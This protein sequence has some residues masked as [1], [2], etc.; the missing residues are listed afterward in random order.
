MV[1]ETHIQNRT[2]FM[3]AV[4]LLFISFIVSAPAVAQM[5]LPDLLTQHLKSDDYAKVYSGSL[6]LKELKKGNSGKVWKIWSDRDNNSIYA[7]PGKQSAPIHG[8]VHGGL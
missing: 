8:P 7:S 3:A 6:S 5:Q 2:N 4:A 1:I